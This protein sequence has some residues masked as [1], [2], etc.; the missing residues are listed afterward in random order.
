M[1]SLKET[2]DRNWYKVCAQLWRSDGCQ[3]GLPP[4][5]SAPL[6]EEL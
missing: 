4:A 3:L 6:Q 1:G 5:A 2:L